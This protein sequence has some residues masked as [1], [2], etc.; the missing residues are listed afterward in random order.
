MPFFPIAI[1]LYNQQPNQLEHKVCVLEPNTKL[2][3]DLLLEAKILR[4]A[5]NNKT[6][7]G[8][9]LKHVLTGQKIQTEKFNVRKTR[10][11]AYMSVGILFP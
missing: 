1:G 7:R 2:N 5:T 9:F 10:Y 6:V 11:L 8:K 4:G 3:G